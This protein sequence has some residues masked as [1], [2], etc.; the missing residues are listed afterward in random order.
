[1][2]IRILQR[3]NEDQSWYDDAYAYEDETGQVVLRY[4]L[5]WERIGDDCAAYV[6]EHG[7]ALEAL[8]TIIPPHAS[9]RWLPVSTIDGD[10]AEAYLDEL[11]K[12]CAIP[13]PR[14]KKVV[15]A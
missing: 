7:I 10:A 9:L 1:M 15:A 2:K 13:Y 12:A 11:D 14:P 6:E 5:T 3:L 4:N 8:E